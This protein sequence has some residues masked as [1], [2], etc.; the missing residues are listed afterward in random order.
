MAHTIRLNLD[1]LD[2]DRTSIH[3]GQSRDVHTAGIH[4]GWLSNETFS[5]GDPDRLERIG[6][7]LMEAARDLRIAQAGEVQESGAAA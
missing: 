2:L 1:D 4:F 5:S 3:V 6:E 7:L